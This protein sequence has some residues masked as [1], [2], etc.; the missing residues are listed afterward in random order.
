M[1]NALMAEEWKQRFGP[2]YY[3][4]RYKDVMFLVIN[5]ELFGMVSDP[6]KPVPGP[7]QQSEQMAALKASLD[8]N[9]DARWTFVFIHQPL[10]D[11]HR[12]HPDWRFHRPGRWCV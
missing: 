9:Q 3:H 6:S 12:I 1:S 2:T 11:T 8:E 10:W 7:E 5:S 4:F